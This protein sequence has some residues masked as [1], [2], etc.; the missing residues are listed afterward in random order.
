MDD[1]ETKAAL[2]RLDE[3]YGSSKRKTTDEELH[4]SKFSGG[5]N[6]VI[7]IS[8]K[9]WGSLET[10]CASWSLARTAWIASPRG[11]SLCFAILTDSEICFF[12]LWI[13]LRLLGLAILNILLISL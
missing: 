13:I 10:N 6:L 2:K 3:F 9:K 7:S 12:V 11:T 1:L 5:S 4:K 8:F